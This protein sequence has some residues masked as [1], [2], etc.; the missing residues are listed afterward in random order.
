MTKGI[1]LGV[2]MIE[3]T[4]RTCCWTNDVPCSQFIVSKLLRQVF[5]NDPLEID[6]SLCIFMVNYQTGIFC[7]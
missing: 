5:L 2:M 1:C 7:C 3:R 6:S 4:D